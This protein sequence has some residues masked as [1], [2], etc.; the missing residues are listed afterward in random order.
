MVE[1]KETDGGLVCAFSGKLDTLACLDAEKEVLR[2]VRATQGAIV[3][4]LAEVSFVVSMFLRL[5]IQVCKEAGQERF[6]IT[7]ACPSVLKVFT[8]AGLDSVIPFK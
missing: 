5:C 6:R 7:N 8:L 2:Q 4:D 1:I 3:F